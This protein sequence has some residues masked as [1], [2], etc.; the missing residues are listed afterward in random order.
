MVKLRRRV[1]RYLASAFPNGKLPAPFE[2][3]R[4]EEFYFRQ[5]R[6]F[7]KIQHTEEDRMPAPKVAA[8]SEYDFT[9]EVLEGWH[10]TFANNP[11]SNIQW[12]VTPLIRKVLDSDA[13]VRTILN[14]GVKIAYFDA[15][16]AQDYPDRQFVGVDFM[17]RVDEF[18]SRYHQPNR[19]LLSGYAREMLEQDELRGDLVFFSSTAVIIR[20]EELRKNLQLIRRHGKYVVFNEPMYTFPGSRDIVDPNRVPVDHSYLLATPDIPPGYDAPP[21]ENRSLVFVHNYAAMV[22]EAGFEVIHY[23]IVM[24]DGVLPLMNLIGRARG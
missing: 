11:E 1:G 21:P 22:E 6:E 10:K 23:E 3:A 4:D 16:L 12:Y 19:K 13:S 8:M 15:I 24:K 20:N 2:K 18:N 7:D 5:L 14:I 9:D 17:R